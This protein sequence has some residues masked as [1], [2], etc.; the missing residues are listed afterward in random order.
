MFATFSEEGKA[1]WNGYHQQQLYKHLPMCALHP[2]ASEASVVV[3]ECATHLRCV[4]Q[5]PIVVLFKAVP[6]P[7][8]S[9]TVPFVMKLLDTDPIFDRYAVWLAK[10]DALVAV[11]V[12]N[13][14]KFANAKQI[15]KAL[16]STLA[17]TWRKRCHS[18]RRRRW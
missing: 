14:V 13:A 9:H 11:D 4:I 16:T 5:V 7:Q 6:F 2:L 17:Q 1:H 15:L 18:R 12:A 8:A 3:L 10:M